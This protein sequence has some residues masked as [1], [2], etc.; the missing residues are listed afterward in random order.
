MDGNSHLKYMLHLLRLREH[1]NKFRREQQ[2][3][4]KRRG[5]KDGYVQ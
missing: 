4:L 3:Q 5:K 2:N 1:S